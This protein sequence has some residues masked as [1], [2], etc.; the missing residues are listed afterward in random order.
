MVPFGRLS[1]YSG[2][3]MKRTT[4][5]KPEHWRCDVESDSVAVLDIPAA[6][7]RSRTFDVDV[8][9]IVSVP[10]DGADAWHELA[11]ELDG[12]RQW[13]R[14]IPSHNPG[15]TDSLEYHC[16]IRLEAEQGLRVRAIAAVHRSRVR[17][18]LIEARE[19]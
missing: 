6:L 19:D 18:L 13:S 15:Q 10:A 9:L 4:L 11:V 12:K 5:P 14:R 7:E 3:I 8:M 17:R 1:R 16:Q 2:A